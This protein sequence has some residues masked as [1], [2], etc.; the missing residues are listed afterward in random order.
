MAKYKGIEVRLEEY[1]G[2]WGKIEIYRMIYV[3]IVLIGLYSTSSK[4]FVRRWF[5]HQI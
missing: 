5:L 1:G 4:R 3:D 2:Y